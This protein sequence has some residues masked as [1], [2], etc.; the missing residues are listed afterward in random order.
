MLGAASAPH[1]RATCTRGLASE[2][3]VEGAMPKVDSSSWKVTFR[4]RAQHITL[5][6]LTDF[7]QNGPGF[8]GSS[9]A[10]VDLGSLRGHLLSNPPGHLWRDKWTALSGPLSLPI[11]YTLRPALCTN[12]SSPRVMYLTRSPDP[13]V[14][15]K[16]GTHKPVKARL[17]TWLEPFSVRKSLNPSKLFRPRSPA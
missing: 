12:A 1:S 4:S 11:Q 5:L 6:T 14:E 15:S 17:G 7:Q 9:C 16:L 3:N 8:R 2:A 13:A 10:S